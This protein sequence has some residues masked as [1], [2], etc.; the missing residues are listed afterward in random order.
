MK[1][2]FLKKQFNHKNRDLNAK[3]MW[4]RTKSQVFKNKIK[5]TRKIKHKNNSYEN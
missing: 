2:I 1:K 4:G 5:Y 3:A